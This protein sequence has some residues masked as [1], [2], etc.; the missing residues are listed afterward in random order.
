[1]EKININW[2]KLLINLVEKCT[3]LQC[4]KTHCVLC[5]I[6]L[7]GRLKNE[8]RKQRSIIYMHM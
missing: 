4:A 3:Q 7:E 2:N 1:M 6:Y 8:P 5:N